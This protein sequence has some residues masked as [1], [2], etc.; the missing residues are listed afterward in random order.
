MTT[1]AYY[2]ALLRTLPTTA[3]ATIVRPE[4]LERI[5]AAVQRAHARWGAAL[6][7]T[8]ADALASVVVRGRAG[9]AVVFRR[10]LALSIAIAYAAYWAAG[11]DA[12]RARAG[13]L[14]E[15]DDWAEAFLWDLLSAPD[16]WVYIESLARRPGAWDRARAMGFPRR[17]IVSAMAPT[18]QMMR[19]VA[20]AYREALAAGIIHERAAAR[21][22]MDRIGAELT[23]RVQAYWRMWV[24]VNTGL[25]WADGY[26]ARVR[27]DETVE[28]LVYYTQQDTRVRPEHRRL[29]GFTAP[30]DDPIWRRLRPPIDYNCRCYLRA[31]THAGLAGLRSKGLIPQAPDISRRAALQI[32][33]FREDA[34][35]PEFLDSLWRRI[36]RMGLPPWVRE[37]LDIMRWPT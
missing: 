24:R 37:A 3:A 32:P 13:L 9:D 36:E 19:I 2:S 33:E 23:R 5:V 17:W 8:D 20:A 11:R 35:L 1:T 29:H 14:A 34:N 30:K 7:G 10:A 31:F 4:D 15:T 28:V 12:E 22:I 25:A 6:E 26:M 21:V 27:A 16:P 18:V